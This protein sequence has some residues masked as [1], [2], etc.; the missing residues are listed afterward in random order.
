MQQRHGRQVRAR[1]LAADEEQ[2]RAEARR[3]FRCQV[4]GRV[5]AVVGTSW[6]RIFRREAVADRH[7][8]EA[9]LLRHEVEEAILAAV[10]VSRFVFIDVDGAGDGERTSARFARPILLRGY[11]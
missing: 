3:P 8:G 11:A 5:V 6:V 1:A 2:R 9:R 7:D 10:M 4:V